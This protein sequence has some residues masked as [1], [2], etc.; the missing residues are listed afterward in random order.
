MS[1][2]PA[3]FGDFFIKP[4]FRA[5]FRHLRGIFPAETG[6][7]IALFGAARKRCHILQPEIGK[8]IGADD[9]G[10]L[11]DAVMAGE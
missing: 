5:V 1:F 9:P 11:V 10:D 6:G 4:V 7:A 2:L 3:I 8:G